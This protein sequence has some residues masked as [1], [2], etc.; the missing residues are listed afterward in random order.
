MTVIVALPMMSDDSDRIGHATITHHSSSVTLRSL[1]TL[2]PWVNW[3]R[4]YR[5]H[6]VVL[7]MMSDDSDR[8][9]TDDE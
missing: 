6:M 3:H 7:K 2:H 4:N 9:V 1:S 5:S 8:S